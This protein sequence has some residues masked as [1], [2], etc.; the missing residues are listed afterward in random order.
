MIADKRNAKQ[1]EYN[2]NKIELDQLFQKDVILLIS[3]LNNDSY[4]IYKN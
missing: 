1:D 4:Q 2:Y 3:F